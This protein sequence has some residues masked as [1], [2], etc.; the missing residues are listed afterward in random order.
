MSISVIGYV[1]IIDDWTVLLITT[2]VKYNKLMIIWHFQQTNLLVSIYLSSSQDHIN[3]PNT[4]FPCES[5]IYLYI[6]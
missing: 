3:Y 1:V 4:M 6:F 5:F 2:L